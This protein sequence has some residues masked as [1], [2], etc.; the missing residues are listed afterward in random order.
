VSDFDAV[1]AAQRFDKFDFGVAVW[2]LRGREG[3]GFAVCEPYPEVGAALSVCSSL[4]P[5]HAFPS[6]SGL[7]TMRRHSWQTP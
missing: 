6:V 2:A 5:V 1:V 7:L 3:V 4:F